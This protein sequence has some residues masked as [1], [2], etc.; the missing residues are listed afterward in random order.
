[1]LGECV[2]SEDGLQSHRQMVHCTGP[3]GTVEAG[4]ATA[5]FH[6]LPGWLSGIQ[7]WRMVLGRGRCQSPKVRS[8]L[9]RTTAVIGKVKL[10]PEETK[11]WVE[12]AHPQGGFHLI[13]LVGDGGCSHLYLAGIWGRNTPLCLT[14]MLPQQPFVF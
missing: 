12:K 6:V 3:A 11:E 14:L 5:H 13:W 1:M 4:S 7:R 10:E 9:V 2:H 8:V